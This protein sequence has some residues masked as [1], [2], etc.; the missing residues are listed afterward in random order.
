V[1]SGPYDWPGLQGELALAILRTLPLAEMNTVQI[2]RI[3]ELLIQV[4]ALQG[5]NAPVDHP[6]H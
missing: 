5:F 4:D 2:Q 6:L 3:K 1:K